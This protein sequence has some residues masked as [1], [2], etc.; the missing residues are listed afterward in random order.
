MNQTANTS[1]VPSTQEK[2]TKKRRKKK[3]ADTS[4]EAYYDLN[5][6]GTRS[7]LI[8]TVINALSHISATTS[9]AL[10]LT[11]GIQRCT[12]S[13]MLSDLEKAGKVVVVKKA[14]CSITG[15]RVKHYA[16]AVDTNVSREEKHV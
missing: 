8:A 1:Q 5:S 6:S 11:T 10:C 14:A 9:R 15:R 16:L 13:G 4:I 7:E 12:M 3:V 2:D